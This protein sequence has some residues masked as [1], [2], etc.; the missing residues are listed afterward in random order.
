MPQGNELPLKFHDC[1]EDKF[2]FIIS[3]VVIKVE[4]LHIISKFLPESLVPF[5]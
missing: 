3:F 4:L 1:D 2:L 5:I